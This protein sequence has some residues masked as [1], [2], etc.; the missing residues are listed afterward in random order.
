MEDRENCRSRRYRK[1]LCGLLLVP[2]LAGGPAAAGGP[3]DLPQADSPAVDV[4]VQP[5]GIPSGVISAVMQRDRVLQRALA[6]LGLPGRF[7]A[8]WRGPEIVPLLATRQLEAGL[9]GDMPTLMAT[10]GGQAVIVGLVKQTSTAVVGRG[11]VQVGELAGRRIA[12]VEGSSAHHTLL[13]GLRSAGLDEQRVKLVPMAVTEM[14]GALA[15]GQ[16]DAFAGWEPASAT[17]LAASRENRVVFRG[18]TS[19]YLVFGRRFVEQQPAAAL[20]LTAAFVR[21]LEWMRRSQANLERAVRWMK[22]DAQALSGKPVA[23]SDEQAARITRQD[24]L[25]VPSAPA[26]PGRLTASPLR[27]EFD[28]LARQGRLPTD[29]R[30]TNVE[31]AFRYE[32]L[33]QVMTGEHRY[34][35]A[36]FDYEN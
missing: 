16:I 32:G 30:W 31:A 28:F 33:A 29:A 36:V 35:L 9:L 11:I 23:V 15:A 21:A 8:F 14:P 6:E 20:Q 10:V 25:D 13:Q 2:L 27:G 4:G 17:A 1:V 12:Y 18:L 3:R 5:L 26:I 34:R 7:H 19:D 22:A 24:I